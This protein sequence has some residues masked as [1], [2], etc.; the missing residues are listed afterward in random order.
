MKNHFGLIFLAA[1]TLSCVYVA[2]RVSLYV[3]SATDEAAELPKAH[4]HLK[5]GRA[6]INLNSYPSRLSGRF[7]VAN[8][9]LSEQNVLDSGETLDERQNRDAALGYGLAAQL[10]QDEDTAEGDDSSPTLTKALR[11][12]DAA[13][14][15]A[16]FK[17][18]VGRKRTLF[19]NLNGNQLRKEMEITGGDSDDSMVSLRAALSSSRRNLRRAV[20]GDVVD[21]QGS[22]GL[23]SLAINSMVEGFKSGLRVYRRNPITGTASGS[24]TA[25]DSN[26][27]DRLG[28]R[29]MRSVVAGKL[30]LQ[31]T[32]VGM[33]Y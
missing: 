9:F 13:L 22:V 26:F 20:K 25:V 7:A 21:H 30:P 12:A 29:E 2:N 6:R 27:V 15:D 1:A 17:K 4:P 33:G 28:R 32:V 10:E 11:S 16:G 18:S 8:K 3:Y 14:A 5:P 23:G 19:G 31:A 24:L